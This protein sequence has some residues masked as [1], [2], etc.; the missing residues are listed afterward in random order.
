MW[1]SGVIADKSWQTRSYL[2]ILNGKTYLI[3]VESSKKYPLIPRIIGFVGM[4]NI[5]QSV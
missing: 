3:I 4:K 2:A 5:M 1:V